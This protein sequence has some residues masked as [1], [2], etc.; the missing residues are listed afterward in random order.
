MELPFIIDEPQRTPNSSTMTWDKYQ[1]LYSNVVIDKKYN[2][3]LKD[4]SVIIVAP[5]GYTTNEENKDQ[6]KFIDS[7]DVVVRINGGWEISPK[8][9]KYLGNKTDVRYHCMMEHTNNGGPYNIKGM[10]DKR[11]KWFCSQFPKNL[12][13]F[14]AD[15]VHFEKLNQQETNPINFHY[16]ADLKY[17][18]QIHKTLNTRMNAGIAAVVDL[19]CYDIKS[20]HIK[21]FTFFKD[22]WTKEHKQEGY[23]ETYDSLGEQ[24]EV[25]HSN[26]PQVEFLDILDKNDTRITL[27]KEVRNVIN[28]WQ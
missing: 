25:N 20:L 16:W 4:K 8:N 1:E 22:G 28:N 5:A 11:V 26:K 3:F 17:Y 24:K 18:L 19:L 2:D 9:Q 27:D 10:K 7:H 14:Y 12:D 6:G 21:G 23:K 13:Y 15:I